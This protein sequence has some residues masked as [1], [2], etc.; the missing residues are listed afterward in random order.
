[1]T[2]RSL[3]RKLFAPAKT[4]PVVRPRLDLQALEAREVPAT[5]TVTNLLDDTNPGS[6]RWAVNQA[7]AA[8]GA[9]TITFA[10]ALGGQT[11][12]LTQGELRL[13]DT[14]GTTTIS[15][16]A[17]GVT[18]SGNNASSVFYVNGG[19]TAALD[20]LSIANG[21]SVGG[22]SAL[23][24]F[25]KLTLTNVTVAHNV[26][27]GL[28][29]AGGISNFHGTLTL[30][31]TTVAH[32]SGGY[33][34]GISN[35]GGRVTLT[36]TTVNYNSA[37]VDGGGI[38]NAQGTVILTNSTVAHNSGRDN[39]GISN[40]SG[41]LTLTN[42]TVAHNS[43]LFAG[44]IFNGDFLTLANSTVVGNNSSSSSSW[45]AGGVL[46][47][48]TLTAQNSLVVGNSSL[49]NADASI[50]AGTFINESSLIGVP[51]GKS[52][53]DIVQVDGNGKALLANNGGPTQTIA[54]AAGSPAIGGGVAGLT[55]TDQRGLARN[56]NPD[57]GAFETQVPTVGVTTAGGT[58]TGTP[59]AASAAQATGLGGITLAAL[60][61]PSLAL[62]YYSGTTLLAGAPSAAG[63]YTVV[64]T[65]TS[66][67][68]GYRNAASES[69]PFTITPAAAAVGLT[70]SASSPLRGTDGL[71]LTAAVTAA[72]S[73]TGVVTFTA[74][75][76]VLGSA[77]VSG[78]SAVLTLT[79]GQLAALLPAG[80]T[81]VTASFAD[82]AGNFAPS[83]AAATFTPVD[84]VR[85]QGL[86]YT[87]ANNDGQVDLSEAGVANV[88]VT[89]TGF[90]DQGNWVSVTVSTDTQG[91]YT[92]AGL[93]PSGP[94]G[95][96]VTEAQPANLL[97]G[98]DTLGTI[99]GVYVGTAGNDT[100]SGLVLGSGA[101]AENYNFGERPVNGGAV[102]AGQTAGIG[103]W[104]NRRGQALLLALNGGGTAGTAT[105]LGNWLAAAFPNL[106]GSLAG[107]TNAQVAA[108]Y[109]TLFAR[110]GGPAPKADA[111]VMA[112]ALAVYV[113]N[114]TLAG[115]T[116]TAYGFT[117]TDTGVGMKTYNVGSSGAAFGVANNASVSVLDLLLAVNARTKQGAAIFDLT[118]NG[119]DT[120]EI[121]Y[122]VM[123]N[124]VF[125]AINGLGGI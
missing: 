94:A 53:G 87:D 107:M 85:V 75:A 6:L 74:G 39:G 17:G 33:G 88:P 48:G 89:L 103:F 97:D 63:S 7:N 29:G 80:A 67:M 21:K 20:G 115:T 22:S 32:N 26:A 24:N 81:T 122:R 42:S 25:G 23:S 40:L 98:L 109:K 66:D 70:L 60:G 34:G 28:N 117:V 111:Q 9:D 45:S 104:Q 14:S 51:Q 19:T 90:D 27:D 15:A 12:G 120:T 86:V 46:N 95:Y 116:A 52:L 4:A 72:P 96:T 38:F 124:D 30:T 105:Q 91:V 59:F 102:G 55:T 84:P 62:S 35:F 114:S 121:G 5:F 8:A 58:Y 44:G 92:F 69:V 93:R 82:P 119:L 106:Y 77:A 2:L 56:A 125:S 47:T 41:T 71:T 50:P 101:T 99:G 37:D 16:P 113:T 123:A 18:V 31:N 36:D 79:A 65:Y 64:A 78:G 57:I 1:M 68:A 100:F 73:P 83:A 43:G 61:A 3:A 10:A 13:T 54:L 108:Y 76:V 110:T 118:G 112:T 11:I 49:V